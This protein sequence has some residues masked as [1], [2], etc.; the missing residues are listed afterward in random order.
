MEPHR[1]DEA[2]SPVIGVIL[3]VAITVTLA[4]VVLVLV[5]RLASDPASAPPSVAMQTNDYGDTFTVLQAD[6]NLAWTDFTASPCTTIPTGQVKAG[7]TVSGCNGQ[8]SLV[9]TRSNTLVYSYG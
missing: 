8:I 6:D 5:S 1:Q 3:M 4:V 7:D 2:V 9:D